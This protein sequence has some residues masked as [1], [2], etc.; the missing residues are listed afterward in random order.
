MK[1]SILFSVLLL[2][3]L[4]QGH[5]QYD[6]A[7]THFWMMEPQFN[8]AAAGSRPDLRVTGAYSNQ[9][10]G[11]TGSPRTMYIG[12][13]MPLWSRHHGGGIYFLNDDIGLFSHKRVAAE[14]ALRFRFLGGQ[15][16][17][18]VQGEI[19]N[20]SFDGSKADVED[21]SDP[22]LPQSTV[23]GNKIDAAA[24]LY[25]SNE[26]FYAG[27]SSLHLTAPTV[28]LGE[29]NEVAVKRSYYF[30]AGYNISLRNPLYTIHPCVRW[31]YDGVSDRTDI[32]L[33]AQYSHE[34]RMLFA[35]ATYSPGNSAGLFVGGKWRGIVLSY[36]YEA[37]TGGVGLG[38]GAH[39]LV[40]S[41]EMPLNMEKK[42]KN[43]HQSVRFL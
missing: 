4:M 43:R 34:T 8:P 3:V 2:A 5:A 28:V 29:R 18:G 21:T 39:E 24:G 17:V 41:Y 15:L 23:T 16:G 31:M 30:T 10:S 32:A 26:H 22:A 12:A 38:N 36:S 9:F 20:E 37:Y 33:R 11:Y 14:Y 27:V 19:L 25:Y 7:F 13:D 35:G 40:L 42:G 1:R 6:V